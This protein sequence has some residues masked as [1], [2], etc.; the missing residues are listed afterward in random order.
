MPE[1]A[2]NVWARACA[3]VTVFCATTAT[4]VWIAA[5]TRGST[6]PVWP[7]IVFAALAVLGAIGWLLAAF[8]VG[9]FKP[10]PP[11]KPRAVNMHGL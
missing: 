6:L 11:P 8:R 1:H 9:P 5:S 7:A 3:G 4:G 2:R 10:P